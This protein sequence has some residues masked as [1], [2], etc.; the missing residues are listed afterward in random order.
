MLTV[1]CRSGLVRGLVLGLLPREKTS[2]NFLAGD[3]LLSLLILPRRGSARNVSALSIRPGKGTVEA[4]LGV[5][6]LGDGEA[7][8]CGGS[9]RV[10]MVWACARLGLLSTPDTLCS[11]IV[12]VLMRGE[13]VV[14]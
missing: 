6:L 14:R 5:G 4:S 13:E 11:G 7:S 2:L 10:G 1:D 8:G 3:L 12:E 9:T